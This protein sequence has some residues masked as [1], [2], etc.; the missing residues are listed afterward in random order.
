MPSGKSLSIEWATHDQET[1]AHTSVLKVGGREIL[2]PLQAAE[3]PHHS[4]TR[5]ELEKQL[6]LTREPYSPLI[7]AG[8]TLKMATLENVGY[9]KNITDDLLRRL[10]EKMVQDRINI[11]FPRIPYS[12]ADVNGNRIP[13]Q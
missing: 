10:K 13:P 9:D 1:L 6:R 11:V 2:S 5:G 4:L 12:Y 7:I 3:S 8:E